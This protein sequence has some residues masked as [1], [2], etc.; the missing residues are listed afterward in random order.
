MHI[1]IDIYLLNYMHNNDAKFLQISGICC[2]ASVLNEFKMGHCS[3][4]CISSFISNLH[5]LQIRSLNGIFNAGCKKIKQRRISFVLDYLRMILWKISTAI[6]I[7]HRIILHEKDTKR[8]IQPVLC[9]NKKKMIY[10]HTPFFNTYT[11]SII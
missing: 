2:I 10:R 1:P 3:K 4:K 8:R 11:V 9:K 5:S 6:S 7:K